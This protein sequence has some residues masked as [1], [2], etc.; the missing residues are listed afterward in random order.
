[1]L[2]ACSSCNSKYLVNSADFKPDGRTVKCVRCNHE[3]FQEPN[4]IEENF[5]ES[6]APST[7]K[8]ENNQLKQEETYTSNLP[9][10]YIKEKDP[11]LF[12]SILAV[13][14]VVTSIVVFQFI[15]SEGNTII[16]LSNFYIQEFFFNLK[17]IIN[18]LKLIINDLVKLIHQ[19]TN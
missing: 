12:N 14:L 4:F 17:L 10:T 13:L 3:W 8:E 11:S 15:K 16:T 19:I 5:F 2:L 1:M 7:F 6:N 9:S 18:D